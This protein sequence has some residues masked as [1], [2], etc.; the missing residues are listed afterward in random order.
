MSHSVNV[1][2]DLWKKAE[3]ISPPNSIIR[4]VQGRDL[5]SKTER[6]VRE[7]EKVN[8]RESLQFDK[9]KK[10]ETAC[11]EYDAQQKCVSLCVGEGKGESGKEMV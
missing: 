8:E 2:A 4:D 3:V 11:K 9:T 5:S 6:R 1:D 10:K 7:R